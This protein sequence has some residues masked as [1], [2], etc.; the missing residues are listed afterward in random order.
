[1]SDEGKIEVGQA[2]GTWRV[3]DGL[4]LFRG[5]VALASPVGLATSYWT[6]KVDDLGE[7]LVTRVRWLK[8][9]AEDH[10]AARYLLSRPPA[11]D[12]E[13]ELFHG[14]VAARLEHR[15][16]L[17][18][19]LERQS[20][21]TAAIP[22]A[23]WLLDRALA[24]KERERRGGLELG[25]AAALAHGGETR[26]FE[27]LTSAMDGYR[28]RVTLDTRLPAALH[29]TK[30]VGE[31]LEV[32]GSVDDADAARHLRGVPVPPELDG[33]Y[34]K[35]LLN[36]SGSGFLEVESKDLFVPTARAFA[37]AVLRGLDEL[38]LGRAEDRA[39]RLRGEVDADALEALRLE[40]TEV[41]TAYAGWAA[42]TAEDRLEVKL[43]DSA[44]GLSGAVRVRALDLDAGRVEVSLEADLPSGPS[45]RLR[46]T[47]G[48]LVDWV[49]N[50]FDDQTGHAGLDDRFL[51]EA[52][53]EG[54]EELKALAS[55]FLRAA[56]VEAE[57]EPAALHA[58]SSV[59]R[60]AA[61]RVAGSL[62][63]VWEALAAHRAG[64]SA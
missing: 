47:Q 10:E 42:R 44:L 36:K 3:V 17:E 60:D 63:Q 40:L 26:G 7:R 28:Y 5:A 61:A 4:F 41:T 57:I 9:Y 37:V 32:E 34:I 39:R 18:L 1:M 48:G 6:T 24:L 49:L 54:L 46:A 19:E 8:A 62:L 13:A 2:T 50:R 21:F 16:T 30:R 27:I 55:T 20:P 14:R 33:A 29:V 56:P 64:A 43:Q 23:R 12:I 58:R 25:E 52:E 53:G 45:A 15:V 51:V 59:A 22:L 11:L 38:N 35:G 31:A